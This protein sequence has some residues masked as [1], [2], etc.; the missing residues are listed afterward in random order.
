MSIP[1]QSTLPALAED[2]GYES[3]K[4][5]PRAEKFCWEYVLRNGNATAAYQTAFPE[6]KQTSARSNA[7]RLL[8][9]TRTQSRIEEIK[10]ELQSRY[11]VS[12]GSLVLY[13]SQ[14]LNMDRRC[15]LDETGNPKT[16][17]QLETE[18]ANIIDLDFVLD[19][20]GKQRAVYRLPTRLQASIELARMMGLHKNCVVVTGDGST[21]E[22]TLTSLIREITDNTRGLVTPFQNLTDD[23]LRDRAKSLARDILKDDALILTDEGQ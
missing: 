5:N 20:H 21:P 3:I 18:A 7:A 16:A 11:A 10:T 12:A 15:F 17:D 2:F 19:R 4:L 14:V 8:K 1:G 13:L 23:D 22:N 9:D 6:S